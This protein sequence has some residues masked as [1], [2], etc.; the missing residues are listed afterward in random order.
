MAKHYPYPNLHDNGKFENY[1][2]IKHELEQETQNLLKERNALNQKYAVDI[3][4]SQNTIIEQ[5]GL[6]E[7]DNP[8]SYLNHSTPLRD[9]DPHKKKLVK[10][11]I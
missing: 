5:S 6:E 2:S 1:N 7:E 10:N 3:F 8:G 9:T 4:P 11:K